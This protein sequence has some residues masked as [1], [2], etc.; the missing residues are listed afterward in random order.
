ME[1]Q[2]QAKERIIDNIVSKASYLKIIKISV[3]GEQQ[4]PIRIKHDNPVM[5]L[6]ISGELKQDVNM[7]LEF[8][9][10]DKNII[11]LAFYSPSHYSGVTP[12][13]R[14]GHFEINEEIHLPET[15]NQ[16]QFYGNLYLAD[17]GKAYHLQMPNA[18]QIEYEGY[19]M[20]TGL[21]FNYSNGSGLLFLK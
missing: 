21:V 7:A 3:N 13:I 4:N 10:T 11:P 20:Q 9:L 1:S 17:P 5:K 6:H 19:P 16:G 2:C 12:V 15:F 14:K 8:R 18:I